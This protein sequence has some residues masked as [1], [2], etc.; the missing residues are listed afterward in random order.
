MVT[1]VGCV[2][3]IRLGHH[4]VRLKNCGRLKAKARACRILRNM[5]TY[6]VGGFFAAVVRRCRRNLDE[7]VRC[8][9]V[10]S[11]KTKPYG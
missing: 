3:G 8:K 7:T 2:R 10:C 1:Y 9:S 6:I 11:Q 4:T 5:P